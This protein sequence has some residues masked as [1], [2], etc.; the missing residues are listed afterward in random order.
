MSYSC[1]FS[2]VNVGNVGVLAQGLLVSAEITV[3]AV[4]AGIGLG[5]LIALLRLSSNRSGLVGPPC[6]CGFVHRRV[7]LRSGPGPWRAS[8]RCLLRWS[9]PRCRWRCWSGAPPG[10]S[11]LLCR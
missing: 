7:S 6:G 10:W 8:A 1:D 11:L 2:T 4:I 5:T 9:T 3:T